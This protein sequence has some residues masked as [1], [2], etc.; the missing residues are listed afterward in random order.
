[1]RWG[2]QRLVPSPMKESSCPPQHHTCHPRS[3]EQSQAGRG[4]R[5][6]S[7]SAACK[8]PRPP[9]APSP[10]QP[11]RSCSAG[12]T[13]AQTCREREWQ[14]VM[15]TLSPVTS[16]HRRGEGSRASKGGEAGGARLSGGGSAAPQCLSSSEGRVK[17]FA[18]GII[19][20]DIC[21][22]MS[23]SFFFFF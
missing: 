14:H 7:P 13:R 19:I 3:D 23:S 4:R 11:R 15:D 6:R 8:Q 5:A 1:M 22:H 20:K 2:G 12:R 10:K 21:F 9:R 18:L 17:V 16:P